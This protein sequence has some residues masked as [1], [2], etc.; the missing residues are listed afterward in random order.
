[1]VRAVVCIQARAFR[2]PARC[3]VRALGMGVGVGMRLRLRWRAAR[4]YAPRGRRPRRRAAERLEAVLPGPLEVDVRAGACFAEERAVAVEAAGDG[5]VLLAALAHG[6]HLISQLQCLLPS[7]RRTLHL[8]LLREHVH[9]ALSR[10]AAG[11]PR[12]RL[13]CLLHLLHLLLQLQVLLLLLL[14]LVIQHR[15]APVRWP[16]PTACGASALRTKAAGG[17]TVWRRAGVNGEYMDTMQHAAG[18]L[19]QRRRSALAGGTHLCRRVAHGCPRS[20][21]RS[22]ASRRRGA[23]C[24]L[25]AQCLASY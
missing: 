4:G 17:A 13:L 19:H 24:G 10:R 5:G 21:V 18:R 6:G 3:L 12:V 15:L 1:V 9:W 7:H 11:G 14:L 2:V 8:L 16:V 20:L 25:R 22:S 23:T